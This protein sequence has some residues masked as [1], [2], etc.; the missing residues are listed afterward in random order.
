VVCEA[1]RVAAARRRDGPAPGGALGIAPRLVSVK[2][3]TNEGMG[4]IGRGEGIA[5]MAVVLVDRVEG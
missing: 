3:K 4:W 5:A 2:G 1:P